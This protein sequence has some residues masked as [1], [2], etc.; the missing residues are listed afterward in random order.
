MVAVISIKNIV[1]GELDH[2]PA[3]FYFYVVALPF[4]GYGTEIVHS[5]TKFTVA[6]R[7]Q[8]IIQ[9]ADLIPFQRKISAVGGKYNG[10][11]A[12]A[13]ADALGN[14]DTGS[15]ACEENV[16]KHKII[17]TR[18][19]DAEKI[20]AGV[21]NGCILADMRIRKIGGYKS[22]QLARVIYGVINYCDIQ[23]A[24]PFS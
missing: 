9:G 23:I 5:L 17:F 19:P 7:F 12:V 18:A 2:D 3:F 8:H 21:I 14:A 6:Q 24:L 22:R 13:F 10:T 20:R 1:N 15:L 11:P 4:L 16:N